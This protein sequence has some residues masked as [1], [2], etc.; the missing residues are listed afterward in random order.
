MWLAG[1]AK[2][3]HQRDERQEG[4]VCWEYKVILVSPSGH[5]CW[6][7]WDGV[8]FHRKLGEVSERPRGPVCCLGIN[9]D[10]IVHHTL[11]TKGFEVNFG[12]L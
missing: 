1:F 6:F 10:T 8:N 2:L 5:L 9:R 4:A 11:L 12:D 7:G 3:M